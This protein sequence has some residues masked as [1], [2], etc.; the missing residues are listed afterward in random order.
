MRI[1]KYLI[2][3]V[4]L[5]TVAGCKNGGRNNDFDPESEFILEGTIQG[6]AGQR[7]WLEEMT[8][9]GASFVDSIPLDENGNFQY[10]HKL[11]YRSLYNLH[12]TGN[13]YVVLLPDV[14]ERVNVQGQ[15]GQLSLSYSVS[16]S[17][18]SVL[19]WQMQE[20]YNDGSWA[21]K[22]I[23]DTA[24]R[25]DSLLTFK[26][27]TQ[28]Q[29]DAKKAVTDSIYRTLFVEQQ[30]YICRFIEENKG[31]LATLIALYKPFNTRALID[32]RDPGSI[33][34]YDMV[35]EGLQE[36][37]PDNPHT[38]KFKNTT[39]HLRS[40]LARQ[41]EVAASQAAGQEKK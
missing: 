33:D 6:G 10:S 19:L 37:L 18:E 1:K 20:F 36:K 28:K 26:S 11:P 4:I 5:L 29:Y 23:V 2:A 13:D 15:W 30:E 40:A 34:Y 25:Y 24:N 16:G 7:L 17:P 12:S 21:L 8:P 31:S 39:E 35:L 27:I 32:P 9:D 38:L 3:A 41:E 22:D 14:G